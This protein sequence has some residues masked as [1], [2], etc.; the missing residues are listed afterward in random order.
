MLCMIAGLIMR[1]AVNDASKTGYLDRSRPCIEQRLHAGIAGRA[2][3]ENII[4]Q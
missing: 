3:G 4:D 1:N 2:A